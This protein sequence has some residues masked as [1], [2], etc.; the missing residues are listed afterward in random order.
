MTCTHPQPDETLGL[1]CAW[2]GCEEGTPKESVAVMRGANGVLRRVMPGP[3]YEV[4]A[5][6]GVTL[7][8]RRRIG[9]GWE[10]VTAG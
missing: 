7:Y 5:D 10:W 4:E 1:P 9:D 6:G 2:P 3:R 8:R